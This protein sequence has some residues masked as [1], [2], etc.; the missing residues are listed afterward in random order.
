MKTSN[1]QRW[2]WQMGEDITETE[3]QTE[4]WLQKPD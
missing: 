4:I 2:S 3:K 1:K